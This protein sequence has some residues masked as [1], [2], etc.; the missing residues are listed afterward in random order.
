MRGIAHAHLKTKDDVELAP[1]LTVAHLRWLEYFAATAD[2]LYERVVASTLCFMVYA[3]AR[4]SNLAKSTHSD[5]DL[6]PDGL[7]GFVEGRVK[8]PKQSR[9]SG[10]RNLYLPLIALFAGLSEVPW[11]ATFLCCTSSEWPYLCSCP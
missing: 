7:D 9:A 1:A 11:G 5:F 10:K 6:T 4:G 8:N 2:D 3:Q